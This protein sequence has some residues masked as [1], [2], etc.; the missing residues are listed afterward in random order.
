[1]GVVSRLASTVGDPAYV[2]TPA[3]I[4]DLYSLPS[5]T[6]V[7]KGALQAIAAF[8]N[9]SFLPSDLATF[10]RANGLA[11]QPV[12]KTIGPAILEKGTAEGE[13]DVEYGNFDVFFGPLSLSVI[14]QL[15]YPRPPPLRTHQPTRPP[16]HNTHNTPSAVLAFTSVLIEC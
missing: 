4:R 9:E 2:I 8:N 12:Y 3:V 14:P 7:A 15:S 5:S 11:D 10:Q 16:P 13:L 6:T 1:M